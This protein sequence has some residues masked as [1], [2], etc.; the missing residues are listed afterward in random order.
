[1]SDPPR[2]TIS[3]LARIAGVSISRTRTYTVMGL[4]R[5]CGFTAAGYQLFNEI[6]VERVRFLAIATR[7]GVPLVDLTRLL[8][9]LDRRQPKE[10]LAARQKLRQL[11]KERRNS[12]T[13]FSRLL[14]R[15]CA[16]NG[17]QASNGF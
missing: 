2:Y 7:A 5:P 3:Q 12:L 8:D 15:V 6:S 13:R 14:D 4:V 11:V 1:M 10:I 9:T 16:H 17:A